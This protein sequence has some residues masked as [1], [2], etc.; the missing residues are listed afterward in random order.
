M[1]MGGYITM[2]FN[3]PHSHF[4]VC[5]EEAGSLAMERVLVSHWKHTQKHMLSMVSEQPTPTVELLY[6]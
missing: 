1:Y 6:M 4:T 5:S 3:I 2:Y